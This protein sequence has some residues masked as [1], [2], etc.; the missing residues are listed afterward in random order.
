MSSEFI[1]MMSNW[2]GNY[3]W[4][5]N[6]RA[7]E[8]IQIIPFETD[9]AKLKEYYTELSQIYLDEVPSFSLM[10]RPE[11]FHN[12]NETVW[13]GFPTQGDGQNIPPTDCTDGYGI[14]ALYHL[15]LVE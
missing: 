5:K 6:D 13:T 12:T 2:N 15:E 7:D 1:G 11:L 3:G 8:L 4:Y 14:A 10:Y 9:Q